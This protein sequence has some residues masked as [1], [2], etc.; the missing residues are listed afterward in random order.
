MAALDRAVALA[1]V[2][3]VAVSVEQD[4]DLD[5]PR[6]LDEALEDQPIVTERGVR[7]APSGGDLAR[8]SREV[9]DG[10]HPLAA[11]ARGGLDQERYADPLGGGRERRVG[12][13]RLVVAGRGRDPEACCEATRGGLVAH[14][15][16]RRRW[17]PDPP[18]TGVD[19]RLG[20]IGVL[21]EEPEARM[22]RVC[23]GSACGVDDRGGVKQVDGVVAAESAGRPRRSPA[24]RT[25]GRSDRAISPRFAM[26]SVA[27]V[28]RA[29][30]GGLD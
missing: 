28:R 9:A 30:F 21:R 10:P 20:E 3:A 19:H 12:L 13:V 18:E 26:K 16:D 22:D 27:M 14:R 23:A 29:L 5:V 4:L 8:Q 15:A 11:T 6:A 24:A 1:E 2:D 17:R 25:F 7:L